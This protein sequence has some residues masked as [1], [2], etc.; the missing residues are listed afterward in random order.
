MKIAFDLISDLHVETWDTE[1]DWAGQATSMLCVVAGDISR[2]R[3]IVKETLQKLGECYRAVFYIDGNDEHRWTLDDLGESYRSLVEELEQIPNVTYLQDNVCIIDGVGFLATNGWWSYDLDPN[4]DYDQTKLWFQDRYKVTRQVAD[5]IE[6]MSM[7]DYA[8]LAKSVSRLQTHK[9]VRRIVVVT[10][11]PPRLDLITHDI[12]L[13]DT[14]RINCSGNSYMQKVL[15][16]DTEQK[17][18]HWCFGHYHGDVDTVIDGVRYV[19]NC[20]GRGN[21]PWSK[22]VYYPRRIEVEV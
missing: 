8:Y 5:A 6:A 11:T 14:Y 3:T 1:F 17:V 16:Q 19:N 20:R 22:P 9:D 15:E 7:Q 12:E 2:D 18:S 21:T 4:V 13:S 10:H